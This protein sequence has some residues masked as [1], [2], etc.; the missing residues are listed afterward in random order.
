LA[1]ATGKKK[2]GSVK[3]TGGIVH[4]R[5]PTAVIVFLLMLFAV[6]SILHAQN[7]PDS[8]SAIEIDTY[9]EEEED[10]EEEGE[11]KDYYFIYKDYR[12]AEPEPD[13]RSVSKAKLEEMRNNKGMWYVNTEPEKE[14]TKIADRT[15]YT[16]IARRS[17]FQTLLWILIIASFAACLMIYLTGN[18]V[19][20]FRRRS[21]EVTATESDESMPEDI[22]AIHYER[23]ISKHEREGNYRMGVRLMFLRTLRKFAD[24]GI[25]AYSQEKTNFDYLV[26]LHPTSYY[27]GFFRVTRAYEY[28]WYGKFELSEAQYNSIKKDFVELDA[29]II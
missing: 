23:E 22:F 13:R 12:E 3:R 2:I 5:I 19:G 6:S 9:D 17:W 18:R 15:N 16:P 25:I 27:A 24:R 20:L 28:T 8:T 11:E 7:P 21:K 14:E 29:K 1:G 4:I 10:G 26:A